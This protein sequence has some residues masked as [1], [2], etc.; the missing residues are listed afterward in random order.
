MAESLKDI[1]TKGIA[2]LVLLGAAFLLF[3]VVLGVVSGLVW[4]A[5]GIVAILAV[6]WALARLL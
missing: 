4:L 1:A 5:I 6:L 3:K 2:L